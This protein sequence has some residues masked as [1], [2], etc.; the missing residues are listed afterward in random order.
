MRAARD[1]DFEGEGASPAEAEG[2][3]GGRGNR[4]EEGHQVRFD[5][6]L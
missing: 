3:P 1:K 4:N 5:F 2:D 6:F